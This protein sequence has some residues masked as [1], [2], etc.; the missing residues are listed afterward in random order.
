MAEKMTV[1]LLSW[2]YWGWGNATERLIKATDAAER[3]GG[4]QPPVFVD[5]RLRRQG[6][7][8]G[9]VGNSFGDLVGA[10]R[11]CWMEDLGN[12]E[13]ATG[14]GGVTIK[15]REA[16]ADLL[17]RAVHAADEGRRVIFYCACEFPKLDGKLTCHRVEIA[18]MLLEHA[19]KVGR[20]ISIVEWP[21][22]EPI[23]T[24]LEV[25]RKLFSA[26]M[27]GRMSIPFDEE[28]LADFAGLPWGSLVALECADDAT[29]SYVA[30]GPA[31]FATSKNGEGFWYLPVIEPPGPGVSKYTLQRHA[32]RWRVSHGLDERRS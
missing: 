27:R 25:D 30:V 1:T 32:E 9:F 13:I 20:S 26:V 28:R 12:A 8:K 31:K 19:K 18:D 17:E 15:R 14:S 22:G 21:G 5:V 24:R 10:S 6:R 29:S 11:Y 3:A 16:V 4:F 7:A 2:G 23:E